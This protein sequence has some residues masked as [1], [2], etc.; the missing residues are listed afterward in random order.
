MKRMF[1]FLF[2]LLC[3]CFIFSYKKPTDAA[4]DGLRGEYSLFLN[5]KLEEPLPSFAKV[6]DNGAGQIVQCDMTHK[7]QLHINNNKIA[8]ESVRVEMNDYTYEQVKKILNF[9]HKKFYEF[10]DG[11]KTFYGESEYGDKFV[12]LGKE[13]INCEIAINDGFIYIGFPVLLGSY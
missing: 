7:N 3:L 8:G 13:K 12:W 9:Q 2:I 5:S 1:V 4:I 10:S 11:L 6:T